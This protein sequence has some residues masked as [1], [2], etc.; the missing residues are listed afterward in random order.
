MTQFASPMI[1]FASSALAV[2]LHV[3]LTP[4]S[5]WSTAN[6]YVD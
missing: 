6:P 3:E 4:K 5:E 1:V 2:N